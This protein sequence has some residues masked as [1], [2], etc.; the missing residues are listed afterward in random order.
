MDASLLQLL[1]SIISGG[2]A[3]TYATN[4]LKS[5]LVAIP[6][7]KHPEITAIIVSL[8]ASIVALVTSGVDL[9]DVSNI[10]AFTSAWAGAIVVAFITYKARKKSPQTGE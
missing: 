6:A 4:L 9:F 7:E 8:L 2:V 10:P 1:I 3:S 5:N